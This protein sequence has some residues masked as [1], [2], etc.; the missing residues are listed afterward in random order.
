MKQTRLADAGFARNAHDV[1]LA[2][3]YSGEQRVQGCHFPIAADD[4]TIQ[5]MHTMPRRRPMP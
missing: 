1:P 4:S 3:S 5:R 2:I